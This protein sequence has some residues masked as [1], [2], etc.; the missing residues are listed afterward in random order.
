MLRVPLHGR[1]LPGCRGEVA[2]YACGDVFR[3]LRPHLRAAEERRY[4]A[5]ELPEP[6]EPLSL[7]MSPS[8]TERVLLTPRDSISTRML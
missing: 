8:M 1:E 5:L 3:I 6:G 2:G 4:H 7:L